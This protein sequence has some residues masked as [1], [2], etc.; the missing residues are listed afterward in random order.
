M[1]LKWQVSSWNGQDHKL[2]NGQEQS[3]KISQNWLIHWI[4]PNH[5]GGNK[6]VVSNYHG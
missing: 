3:Q 2:V 6:I 5:K 4:K 1:Q